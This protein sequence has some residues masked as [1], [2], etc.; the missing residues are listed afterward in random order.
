MSNL[1]LGRLIATKPIRFL[2]TLE[3]KLILDG[4]F[5]VGREQ[6]IANHLSIAK[7][8]KL[9]AKLFRLERHTDDTAAYTRRYNIIEIDHSVPIERGDLAQFDDASGILASVGNG[10]PNLPLDAASRYTMIAS[11]NDYEYQQNCNKPSVH[12]SIISFEGKFGMNR[13]AIQNRPLAEGNVVRVEK[14]VAL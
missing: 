3:G 7:E 11:D 4:F 14:V 5:N 9:T 10:A 2:T 12:D 13:C 1:E 8:N 6:I